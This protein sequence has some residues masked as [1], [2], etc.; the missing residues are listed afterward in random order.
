MTR[1]LTAGAVLLMTTSA[2]S[3]AGIERTRNPYGNLFEEG[4]Y[5]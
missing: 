2:L 4:G 3:A 5:L 1:V